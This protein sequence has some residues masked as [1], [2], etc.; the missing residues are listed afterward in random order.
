MW[1]TIEKRSI[2]SICKRLSVLAVES[3][4]W[5]PIGRFCM[6]ICYPWLADCPVGCCWDEILKRFRRAAEKDLLE[7]LTSSKESDL[8]QV[9]QR[10][11]GQAAD[12]P[13][14]PTLLAATRLTAWACRRIP[15]KS[16]YCTLKPFRFEGVKD[17]S[18]P[19]TFCSRTSACGH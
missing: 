3:E 9:G 10:R 7:I 18:S 15:E 11:V 16:G 8:R 1:Q 13:R 5:L 17:D 2:R 12:K 14:R 4:W 6:A 19:D